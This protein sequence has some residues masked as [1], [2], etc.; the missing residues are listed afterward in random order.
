MATS[1]RKRVLF[2]AALAPNRIGGIESYAAELARQLDSKGWNLTICYQAEAR[3]AVR[4]FLLE[5]GNVTLDVQEVQE[6]LGLQ[7]TREFIKL[8]LRHR[9]D[10]LLYTLGGPVRLWPLLGSLLGVRRRIYHDQT[11]RS[12]ARYNYRAGAKVQMLMKPLSEAI[13]ATAFVKACSDREQII[14]A[15]KSRVIYSAVDNHRNLGDAGAFREKYAIPAD[16]R[17]VLQVSWL[18][19]EKGIDVALRAARRVLDVRQDLQFVFCGDGAGREEYVAMAG[20]LGIADHVTWCGQVQD[21]AASGAW[22]AASIQIQCSQWHEAFCLSVAEGMS[23]GLPV[24]ASRIGGLPELVQDGTNGFVFEP[25]D[26]GAL[27][28]GILKLAG[29]EALRSKMGAAG[30]DRALQNL[31]L[32]QN[33]AAWVEVLI[34]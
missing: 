12:A 23:A 3:G 11:S 4:E 24:V 21:L 16:R 27:A 31:D 32:P 19:P 9:P 5:P 20:D 17:I 29:D 30:R 28:E 15:S 26:D 2:L 1:K 14:P 33:V 13:C 6:G 8:V 25:Q 22:P 34:A 10:V 7:N 18:V